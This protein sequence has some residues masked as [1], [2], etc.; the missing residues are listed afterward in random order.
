MQ[1][2]GLAK[3]HDVFDGQLRLSMIPYNTVL[4]KITH[5]RMQ[6]L[7]GD[8]L[9]SI[10]GAFA[11]IM[12]VWVEC[13]LLVDESELS[14]PSR[15]LWYFWQNRTGDVTKDYDIFTRVLHIDISEILYEAYE[16][17]R[18]EIPKASPE[19]SKEMPLVEDDPLPTSAGGKRGKKK[20]SR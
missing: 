10:Q 11:L 18:D 8:D 19:L 5:I 13:E 17:T 20:S 1:V 2:N 12:G 4:T 9:S 3:S 6:E 16:S 15:G 7:Y 14:L